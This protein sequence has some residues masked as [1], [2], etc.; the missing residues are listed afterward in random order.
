MDSNQS[1]QALPLGIALVL[2][3]TITGVILFNTG[4]VV[5]EKTRLA[6]SADSAVYS[7]ALWQARALNFNAYVNRAMVANQVAMAQAVSLQSWAQYARTA[8]GNI[9]AVLSPVP[10]VG[11]IAAATKQVMRA[12][13]SV[14]NG[15][16][17]GMLA[18]ID[19]INSALSL[20]QEAMYLSAFVASP[21]IIGRIAEANDARVSWESVFSVGHMANNLR[22]WQAFTDRHATTDTLAMDE[23][24]AMI[25]A[26]TDAFTR[27][28]SWEFF[29]RYLPVTPLHWARLDRSGATRLLRDEETGTTEWKAIDTLSL[30]NKLYYW[31]GRHRRV[32]LPIGYSMKFANKQEESIEGCSSILS[33]DCKDWFGRNLLAQRLARHVEH[34][35]SGGRNEAKSRMTY[36]GV[37]AYRSLSADIR[38]DNYPSLLLRTE[39]RLPVDTV[40]DAQSKNIVTRH[41]QGLEAAS[42]PILSSVSSAEIYFNRPEDD[43][44]E[45]YASGYNPFW[46]V[47]LAPTSTGARVAAMALR[48]SGALSLIPTA[49]LSSYGGQGNVS[50]PIDTGIA[51]A[52]PN[53]TPAAVGESAV[54]IDAAVDSMES[55][56]REVLGDVLA[57]LM[58]AVLPGGVG[59]IDAVVDEAMAGVDIAA[60]NAT[61]DEV[62]AQIDELRERYRQARE[63]IQSDFFESVSQIQIEVDT[64]RQDIDQ[65][66]SELEDLLRAGA[67]EQSDAMQSEIQTLILERDGINGAGG[68]ANEMRQQLAQELVDIVR[69]TLP[70]LPIS[71]NQA[72]LTVNQYFQYATEAPE[73]LGIHE[74]FHFEDDIDE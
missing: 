30:N 16:G 50:L 37:R 24:V 66:I 56:L 8:T 7:G 11:Q 31:F 61:V 43:A 28:R 48:G 21:Q 58:N 23:R 38:A 63:T 68:L 34:D 27:D 73:Q 10:I 65:R 71:F 45:E 32:E 2:A 53:W 47:R 46:A 29:K 41:V 3:A 5:N 25:N 6:N 60:I 4:Q 26:S 19:P 22:N 59:S 72:L 40:N 51:A 9:S 49:A 1:G 33:N 62:T 18:V 14:V 57:R 12:F 36:R 69:E 42:E 44:K 15:L 55:A 74:F 54:Q 70:E 17:N 39:L 67:G 13:E 52:L 20:S 35:L 64:R